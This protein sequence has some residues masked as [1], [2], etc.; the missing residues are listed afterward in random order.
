MSENAFRCTFELDEW[1][2][3][4][5][6]DTK[7][8]LHAQ[9]T[10]WGEKKT[11]LSLKQVVKMCR[12][13]WLE[14]HL[15][16]SWLR[17]LFSLS[18]YINFVFKPPVSFWLTASCS[19]WWAFVILLSRFNTDAEITSGGHN[20]PVCLFSLLTSWR[21]HACNTINSSSVLSV[22]IKAHF[23]DV[24]GLRCNYP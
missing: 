9:I 16:I 18:S 5:L 4:G 15:L 8:F 12:V 3:W 2:M 24:H 14:P 7:T 23:S 10:K 21:L 11:H 6:N 19:L 17:R 1:F 20:R 13:T 22:A